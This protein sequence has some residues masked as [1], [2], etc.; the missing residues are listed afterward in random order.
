MSFL[1]PAD[2]PSC[3]APLP[4]DS[5]GASVTSCAY[6]EATL[7]LHPSTVFAARFDRVFSRADA[8]GDVRVAGV[9]YAI[10]KQVGRGARADV[11][12]AVRVRPPGERVILKLARSAALDEEVAVLRALEDST[13]P[14]APHFRTRLP[15]LVTHAVC[16][17]SGRD[18]IVFRQL[19]GFTHTLADVRAQHPILDAKHAAWILRRLYELLAWVHASGFCHGAISDDH[20]LI[21]ARDHGAMLIG[22]SRGQLGDGAED[23][24]AAARSVMWSPLPGAVG[25]AIAHLA[26]AGGDAHEAE[27]VI[28]AAARKDFGPP[29]FV[30]LSLR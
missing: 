20:V 26:K 24:A 11:Y 5:I 2:C 10:D 23:V 29:R 22:W 19:S 25:D 13:A 4:P 14:G 27:H 30:P 12:T 8:G 21:N 28:A 16:E 9:P 1:T 15:Q 18:A 7:A 3:G 6:C 17:P